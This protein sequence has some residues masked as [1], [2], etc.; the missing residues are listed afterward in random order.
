MEKYLHKCLSS[1]IVSAENMEKMEVL[2]INDGSKDSSS[3]IGHEYE[4]RHPQTFRV[5]DKENGNYGSCINRGLKEATGK[6]VKVLDADDYYNTNYLD[7]YLNLIQNLDVD[8]ILNDVQLVDADNRTV[9]EWNLPCEENV[10][11]PWGEICNNV[12]P[13]MHEVAFKKEN[14]LKI[15]YYQTEGIS[16]TDQQWVFAPISTIKSYYYIPQKI[17]IYLVGREGQTMDKEVRMKSLSQRTKVL[18]DMVKLYEEG[19]YD[20]NGSKWMLNKLKE[21]TYSLF[22]DVIVDSK[23]D[24]NFELIELDKNIKDKCPVFYNQSIDSFILSKSF[25]FNYGSYWRKYHHL[26]W[27]NPILHLY[28]LLKKIK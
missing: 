9:E 23:D 27:W 22:K 12:F 14:L 24:R 6:Y 20:M 16:Y 15:N 8:M 25:R 4:L 2:I 7:I 3:E 28:Y 21:N 5:I 18:F 17:Y 13:Q 10:I 1:L 26:N 11:K 19:N